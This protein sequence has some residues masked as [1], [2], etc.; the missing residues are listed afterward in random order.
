M[1]KKY[2]LLALTFLF[3]FMG[4]QSYAQDY[5]G[6][7]STID[8]LVAGLMGLNPDIDVNTITDP[9]DYVNTLNND[10]NPDNDFVDTNGDGFINTGDNLYHQNVAN[11]LGVPRTTSNIELEALLFG[12]L[13]SNRLQE[14]IVYNNYHNLQNGTTGFTIWGEGGEVG[15]HYATI[16]DYNWSGI[17]GT[18]VTNGVPNISGTTVSPTRY[19]VNL[20]GN[21][22]YYKWRAADFK[23]RN[24]NL[25]VPSYYMGYGDKYL[26]AFTYETSLKLSNQGK[27]WLADVRENLQISIENRL[28]LADGANFE[29]NNTAFTEFAFDSHVDAYWNENGSVKLHQL[30]TLDLVNILLT[31]DANDLFSQNGLVQVGRIS[32]KFIDYFSD[33]PQVLQDRIEEA[34]D[35]RTE[36][37]S[38]LE[39]KAIKEGVTTGELMLYLTPLPFL[40]TIF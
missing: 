27:S 15:V 37:L 33:N 40:S 16:V 28:K 26:K 35:N 6:G 19:N 9:S 3:M 25:P 23:N 21:T 10:G 30:G 22:D 4:Q 8:K 38:L 17:G 2:Y 39:E 7:S 12:V 31:P 14:V 34:Y 36:I 18:I 11:T 32:G 13:E 20:L 29:R 5:N 1:E 24:P